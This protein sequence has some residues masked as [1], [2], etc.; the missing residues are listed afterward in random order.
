MNILALIGLA[1]IH[2]LPWLT[3][4]KKPFLESPA[5]LTTILGAI[6]ILPQF[7]IL[8]FSP[9]RSM[10]FGQHTPDFG[11]LLFS[12]AILYSLGMLAFYAGLGAGKAPARMFQPRVRQSR[13]I[14]RPLTIIALLLIAYLALMYQIFQSTGGL[15]NYLANIGARASLLAGSGI[16]FLF[17]SPASYMIIFLAILS[18]AQSRRPT[19]PIL[20]FLVIFL[21]GVES[22]L[23][24]R[25][26]PVQMLIFAALAFAYFLPGYK[27]YSGRNLMLGIFAVVIFVGLLIV[28]LEKGESVDATEIILNLS[29]I[30]PYLFVLQ[31]FGSHELWYGRS[32]LDLVQ[33]LIPIYNLAAPSPID[34]GVYIY[35]LFLGRPV[36]PPTPME[37]MS[38]NSWPA[39][40]FGNGYMNFGTA[41]VI[42]FFFIRG[43]LISVAYNISRKAGHRPAWLLIYL[44]MAFGFQVSNLKIAQLLMLLVGLATILPSVSFVNRVTIGRQRSKLTMN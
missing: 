33:R 19:L 42:G 21:V 36:S 11:S 13:K 44:W 23:G 5:K 38:W 7:A 18:Y 9:E 12:F 14:R 31:H 17:S 16:F 37:A 28:R 34:E 2:A 1:I 41:G 30:D 26:Q 20:L 22:L 29:H 10:V 43:L 3:M 15:A 32:F 6:Q 35:N 4:P 40:T 25:R 8:T 39:G 24:G 27:L